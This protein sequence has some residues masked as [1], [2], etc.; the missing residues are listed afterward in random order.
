MKKTLMTVLTISI[1][2]AM[3]GVV[4]SAYAMP[5]TGNGPGNGGNGGGGN[6]G[7]TAGTNS[8]SVLSVYMTEAMADVLGIDAVTLA[9]QLDAGETFYTIASAAGY[10]QDEI[11][12]LIANARSIATDLAAADGLSV[13]IQDQLNTNTASQL[14]TN[15][16]DQS[17][18]NDGTC[19]GTGDCIPTNNLYSG[20]K[21]SMNAGGGKQRSGR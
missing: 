13:Q 9:G 4:G 16:T 18:L 20:S 6:S 7:G 15:T 5:D 10:S 12:G 21:S 3:F 2:V 1:F 19:D 17:Q 8:T 14:Y 11:S